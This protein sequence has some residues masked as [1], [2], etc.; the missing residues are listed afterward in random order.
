MLSY[1]H[2]HKANY[3]KGQ[4]APFF[5]LILVLIMIMAMVSLNLSKVA[6]IKTASSNAVDAGSLSGASVM[7]N[8]FNGIAQANSEMEKLYWEFFATV[9]AE[10][11]IVI[12]LLV[13]S[14]VAATNALELALAALFTEACSAAVHAGGA[15]SFE[16]IFENA[17][18]L[19]PALIMGIMISI[20]AFSI[21][22]YF[23]YQSMRKVAE[24]GRDQAIEITHRFAFINSGLGS[25]LKEGAPPAEI[26]EEQ[27]KNN[28]REEFSRFLDNL[29]DD[30]E[31]T[32]PWIDGETRSHSVRVKVDI[33]PV[34][35]F[36]LR[37]TV[38]PWPTE[39]ALLSTL[40]NLSVNFLYPVAAAIL[41][42]A[43]GC[44]GCCP[45]PPCCVC[46][47][48]LE[49]LGKVV[50]AAGIAANILTL[51]KLMMIFTV[52]IP[53]WTGL[54][55]GGT[56][57]ADS[58]FDAVPF[59]IAWIDDIE[60]ARRLRIDTAQEHQG[61]D[62][63]LWRTRYST[64]DKANIEGFSIADF[65]GRGSIHPPVFRHDSS[66]VAT[67]SLEPSSDPL[68][69]CDYVR[70]QIASLGQKIGELEAA[71]EDYAS[72]ADS[73]ERE[74]QR[75][76]SLNPPMSEQADQLSQSAAD[77]RIRA[78]QSREQA[79]SYEEEIERY[80]E[81]NQHCF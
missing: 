28:Y 81:D 40:L 11:A 73:L 23:F 44:R 6:S 34:D 71:A 10:F 47:G 29:D 12:G 74:A 35:T 60:H 51:N 1:F 54:L 18:G 20:T 32:Y 59:T 55:P 46:W 61:G 21:A 62:L 25:K 53:A 80:R 7:A 76:R 48:V 14:Q 69:I 77:L 36:I 2:K 39:V 19:L 56:I 75:L 78:E 24:D 65:R 37:T 79:D 58:T 67:D 27:K 4:M 41:A 30:D 13:Q 50:L 31:Y 42:G 68:A 66:I 26:T 5:I 15:A 64:Q 3:E 17:S 57:R 9:S 8:V 16:S 70:N 43:C 49:A 33:A 45:L 22:Q 52:I 63:G 72:R 38:L